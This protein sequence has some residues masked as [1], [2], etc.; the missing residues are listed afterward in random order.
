MA[1]S[2]PLSVIDEGLGEPAYTPASTRNIWRKWSGNTVFW[3][4]VALVLLMLLHAH[5]AVTRSIN[6]D[7]FHFLGQVHSFTRGELTLPLQSFHVRMFAW[8]APLDLAGVDQIRI[9]RGFMFVAEG[10]TCAAIITIARRFTSMPYAILSAAAYL[11]AAYV[12]QHGWSFRTDPIATALSM[13]SLAILARARL[14]IMAIIG[15]ALLMGTAFMVTMKIVLF[16]P[17]FI[18]IAYLRWAENHHS[19]KSALTIIAAPFAA[20]FVAGLLFAWHSLNL[21]PIDEAG[22]L[23]SHSGDSMFTF[24]GSPN[25]QYFFMVIR[26]ALPLITALFITPLVIWKRRKELSRAQIIALTAM[27]VMIVTPFYYINTFPYFYAFLL[28]P[29]AAAIG[30]GLQ[31]L[32]ERYGLIFLSVLLAGW[33]IFAWASEGE[34]HLDKQRDIQI[35]ANQMFEEPVQYLDFPGYF[36]RHRKANP[37]LTGWGL[38]NYMS[39]KG[40]KFTEILAAKTVPMMATIEPEANPSLLSAMTGIP[41]YFSFFKEDLSALQ[42]TYRPVWGPLYV[43]GTKLNAGETKTWLVRVPGPYKADAKIT[44]NGTDYAKGDIITL[45]R[46]AIQLTAPS[47]IPSGVLWGE[48]TRVPDLPVPERPYWTSF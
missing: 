42:E 8:L 14:N 7:E 39:G 4:V 1:A 40:A 36:P 41:R 16:A 31:E 32:G 2:L 33:G 29:I 15:F 22:A 5:L 46:G 12:M 19:I 24:G 34:S 9:A 21:A 35:A 23:V 47:D 37:F 48:N 17:A 25:N 11:S 6:W 30:V 45:E 13:G 28:A 18:G 38:R 26:N 10:I 43:A 3:P 27:A 20:V 44:V